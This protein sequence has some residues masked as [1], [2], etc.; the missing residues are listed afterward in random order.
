MPWVDNHY[1]WGE[2]QK[3]RSII[4]NEIRSLNLS[5]RIV[6]I[7]GDAHMLAVD[8]GSHSEGGVTVFQA[9]A[10]DAKP[11]SKGGPYSHGI[12]PGRNQYGTLTVQDIGGKIC[13]LFQGWRW[14]HPNKVSRLV[15]YDTCNHAVNIPRLYTPSPHMI[16][17]SWKVIK[18]HMEGSTY[19]LVRRLVIWIDSLTVSVMILVD[20]STGF[21]FSYT[22]SCYKDFMCRNF[23]Q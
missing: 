14:L 13:F 3:E 21:V 11:T 22:L 5:D 15:L 19:E 6:I 12:W 7:S 20:P 18:K 8:D 17:R 2:F 16:Q 10:L 1:K 23:A 9:A 4:G